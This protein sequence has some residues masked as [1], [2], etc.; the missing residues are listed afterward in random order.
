M[1]YLSDDEKKKKEI[2]NLLLQIS[3]GLVL[4]FTFLILLALVLST[5]TM[6]D[7]LKIFSV[8]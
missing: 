3:F 6:G 8:F 4:G 5:I 7:P 2:K 1:N